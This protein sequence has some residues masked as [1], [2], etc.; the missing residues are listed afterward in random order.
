MT[1]NIIIREIQQKDNAQI[2]AAIR[3]CFHEFGIPLVGTAYEDIETTQ[4]FE[5]YQDEKEVYF[6]IELDEKVCGGG[7][8]KPL[9]DFDADVCEIQKMYFSPALRGKGLGKLLFKKCIETAKDLGFKQIYLESAPQLK[10][11]IH[12]YETFGF[13]HLDAPLGDTGH[14]S[15]GVWMLKKL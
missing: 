1:N 8:V 2:E 12:I 15:C 5:S 7:G 3:A 6:V 10:A 4:M 11:A 14:S 9:K 13:N